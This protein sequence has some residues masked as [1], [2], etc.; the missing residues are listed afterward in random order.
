MGRHAQLSP[1]RALWVIGA[2]SMLGFLA[3]AV[4]FERIRLVYASLRE[5]ADR[6]WRISRWMVPSA[7][8]QWSAANLFAVAAPIYYGAAAAG[9]L[10][11]A[12]NIVGVA[13]IWFLG[14]DN[15]VPAESARRLHSEG[16]D[17]AFRYIRSILLRWGTV[18]L[19][20]ITI[21][22]FH[23]D[24]WLKLVYGNK[25]SSYGHILQ[26]YAL[27]YMMVFFQGP[28]RAGLQTLEYTAPV[29]W[30]YSAMTIFSVAFAGPSTRWLGLSGAMLGMI[31]TQFL[32][33][34]I[35]G[36]SL[37]LRVRRLRQTQQAAHVG[38]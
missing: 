5:V 6:H 32:G 31:V 26:L 24:F 27:Y 14:L 36:S 28:L 17:S 30:S 12:Q 15:V 22:S 2:T 29:F 4:K 10:R 34:C 23:P 19:A 1:S 35:V 18:T 20:F 38:G 37:L 21:I 7:F 33:Q 25:Y 9:V 13:H 11:S 16:L 3:G 8:M